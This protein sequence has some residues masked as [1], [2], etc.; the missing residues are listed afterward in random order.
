MKNLP[1]KL[2]LL[3]DVKN[4]EYIITVQDQSEIESYQLTRS[5]MS[6]ELSEILYELTH[7][8]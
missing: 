7:S 6:V 2:M 5:E 8:E 1:N 3:I 4:D